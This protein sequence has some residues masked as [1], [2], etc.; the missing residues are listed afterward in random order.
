MNYISLEIRSVNRYVPFYTMEKNYVQHYINITTK[1]HN[2][3]V[4][5]HLHLITPLAI[6][7]LVHLFLLVSA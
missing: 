3:N 4:A 6:L 5:H 1:Q 7:Y 2:Y